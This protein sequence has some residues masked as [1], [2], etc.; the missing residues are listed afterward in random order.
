MVTIKPKTAL[1]AA[2][3]LKDYPPIIILNFPDKENI[4]AIKR[5]AKEIKFAY[6]SRTVIMIEFTPDKPVGV[7]VFS[8]FT[9]DIDSYYAEARRI[10]AEVYKENING[11]SEKSTI[12]R[13]NELNELNE[14]NDGTK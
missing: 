12:R 2:A 10:L 14:L 7:R 9:V 11:I 6:G 13:L 1:E 5:V 8:I 3:W 4:D